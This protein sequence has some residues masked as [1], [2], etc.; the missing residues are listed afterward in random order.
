[1]WSTEVNLTDLSKGKEPSCTMNFGRMS[2]LS[3]FVVAVLK[4]SDSKI[5]VLNSIC[6]MSWFSNT[7]LIL[8]L[9]SLVW[10]RNISL[11]RMFSLKLNL[12]LLW[13]FK[14]VFFSFRFEFRV[15]VIER[16]MLSISATLFILNFSQK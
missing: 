10:Y 16:L 9:S 6:F 15:F 5:L 3:K 4:F 12:N 2:V 7:R 1:M 14:E 13:K 8:K 11:Q